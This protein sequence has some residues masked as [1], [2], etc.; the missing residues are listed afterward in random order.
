[1][2]SEKEVY[3]ALIKAGFNR[4]QAAGIMGNIQNESGF[5]PEAIGDQG[6]SFGLVQWHIPGYPFARSLVTGNSAKDFAAQ[7][8]QIVAQAHHLNLS[9]TAGQVAGTWAADFE[10]CVGCQP[11]GAQFN[12]RVANANR[13][14][15]Q[16][17]SGKWPAPAGGGITKSGGSSGSGSAGSASTGASQAELTA[18]LAGSSGAPS[19]GVLADAGALLHGTAVVLDRAFGL[20]APGQGWRI[21][22]GATAVASGVGSWHAFRS[23]GEDGDGNLPLAILLTGVAAVALF[24]AARPWPQTAAG[25]IKPGA[26]LVDVLEGQPPPAGP[27]A[28]TP[29]EVHLTEAGLATL[30]ALWAAGKVGQSLGGIAAGAGIGGILGKVWGWVK[31]LGTEVGAAA[32]EPGGF[33][34]EGI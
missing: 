2:A 24:M 4:S 34:V 30:L 3:D 22:F 14:F 8:K 27:Q 33:P 17:S 25:A 19:G 18:F 29:A 7:I 15:Q 10:K 12:A 11:G 16:A 31:G 1:M 20:F 26:Y 23:G 28:F 32:G 9:G 6:T 5:N 13:I 21:V